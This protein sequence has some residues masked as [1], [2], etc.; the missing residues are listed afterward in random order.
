MRITL[1][2]LSYDVEIV[3]S[4]IFTSPYTGNKL[5]KYEITFIINGTNNNNDLIGL[6]RKVNE[7]EFNLIFDNKS[8]N[9]DD[10]SY[11]YRDA[12]DQD[13]IEYH[14]TWYISEK[15]NLN[16]EEIIINN[17]TIKPYSY[18][19]EIDYDALIITFK[20]EVNSLKFNELKQLRVEDN[21]YLKVI[22]KGIKNEAIDMRFGQIL[23]S[24]NSEE[25][26]I[27]FRCTLVEKIY[28]DNKDGGYS[29]FVPEMNNMQDIIGKNA[30]I[31]STLIDVLKT[32]NVLST[33][34]I[35]KICNPTKEKLFDRFLEFYKVNELDEF[36]KNN[37]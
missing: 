28:D 2:S 9:I 16:I 31:L 26:I 4:E 37:S 32:K 19:E 12:F 24:H 13:D 10:S 17:L 7:G 14:H 35:N 30:E 15:E 11:R 18:E 25:D 20:A 22:R 6:K 36:L 23:W 1:G 33:E 21:E 29:L 8:Y 3:S 34:E 27:K 5:N